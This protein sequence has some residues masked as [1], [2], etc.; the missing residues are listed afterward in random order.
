MKNF[1]KRII[2]KSDIAWT[3][4]LSLFKWGICSVITG[5]ICGVIGTLFHKCVSFATSYRIS[6]PI[7]IYFLP[8]AGLLIVF[9]YHATS[10]KDDGGTNRIISSIRTSK[11]IPFRMAPLIF[12]STVITHLFGGSA[13]REGAAL[14]IGGSI[15]SSIGKVLKLDEK[16]I[17]IITMCGMSGVFSALFGTPITATIFSMEVISVGVL[18]YVAFI[19][20]L[21][22]AYISLHFAEHFG[23]K[24][25]AFSIKHIPN[26]DIE[27]IIR[28]VILSVLCAG[29]SMAFCFII[30]KTTKLY[31]RYLSNPYLRAAVGGM[32]VVLLTVLVQTHDYNGAGMDVVAKAIHGEAKPEAFLLK[33]IFTVL[34]LAA[35]FKG[36]EIVPS[37][38]IGATFGNVVGGLLGLDPGFGAAIGLISLF[39][40][41][42]NCPIASL[43]L[44]I[45][46]FGAEALL[47]F[48]FACAFSYV[49]SGYYGLYSSQKIVYSK[50]SP[51]YINKNIY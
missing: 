31:K 15:G 16:D 30:N 51:T 2:R 39:C 7:I 20:C 28:V 21:V 8:I 46:L 40:G 18:Y 12:V 23:V 34:T 6:H 38:F 50:V 25:E 41:V 11:A 47:L 33:L 19:P 26:A 43:V 49:L 10:M 36:G 24:P 45:E 27:T 14:Q 29:V 9:L 32:V 4:I 13:G 42:V 35:G 1:K 22:S 37:F 48:C 17:H 3:F 44:S 5:L